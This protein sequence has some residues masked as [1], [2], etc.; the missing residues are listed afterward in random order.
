M[1]D[2]YEEI[3]EIPVYWDKKTF[4]SVQAQVIAVK[5]A[6]TIYV[7]NLSFY[8]REEQVYELFRT[9]GLVRRIILGLDRHRRNPC[10][11]AFVE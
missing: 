6:T 4:E 11:F 3:D 2:L 8:T 7:G 9:C 10:G 1:A 5:D